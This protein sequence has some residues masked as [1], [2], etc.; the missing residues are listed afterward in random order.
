M[1]QRNKSRQGRR[2]PAYSADSMAVRLVVGL[3]LIALGLLI[4]LSIA[5]SMPGDVFAGV[6]QVS[7][8]LA[9][10]LAFLLPVFP[11]WGGGLMLFSVQRKVPLW[12]FVMACILYMLA[13]TA[14]VLVSY[15]GSPAVSLME[16]FYQLNRTRTGQPNAYDQFL[17][18]A[19]EQGANRGVSG[20]LLGMLLAWPVWRLLGAVPG[21]IVTILLAIVAAM[22]MFR[23]TP[24][25]IMAL[26]QRGSD[27]RQQ[28]DEVRRREM[29]EQEL[30][31]QQEQARMAQQQAWQYQQQPQQAL[32][33][34]QQVA[35]QNYQQPEYPPQDYQQP[36]YAYAQPVGP[37]GH[38]PSS[39]VQPYA[40]PAGWQENE[41]KPRRR[42][43]FG[44]I[45]TQNEASGQDVPKRRSIFSRP[46]PAE[47][48][49]EAETPRRQGIFERPAEPMQ[50]KQ[51]QP[52][53]QP[54]VFERPLEPEELPV[55][56]DD[57]ED[58]GYPDEYPVEEQQPVRPVRTAQP[59]AW[60]EPA[61]PAASWRNEEDEEPE[62]EPAPRRPAPKP[63]ERQQTA[64]QPVTKPAPQ[65][66]RQ[67]APVQQPAAVK[68]PQKPLDSWADTPPWEDGPVPE[69]PE[70]VVTP[71]M[72]SE[73]P[74]G[75]WEADLKLPPRRD[76]PAAQGGE[77]S[78]KPEQM[79][80]DLPVPYV[81]PSLNLLKP[82][83]PQVGVSPE[84]DAIRSQRL[85]ATLESFR[86]PAKV[87]HIT[88]GP[89]ISRF[90]L[91]LA[92]G[93]KVNKVTDLNRNIAMNMEVKSVRIE[94]P[95]PGKSLVGVEV[96][97]AKTATVTLR[98]VLESDVMRRSDK[99]L[100]VALGKDIAGVPIVCDL[101]RMPHLLIAGATG[102]GKSVCINT[103]INSLLFRRTPE[104]VRLILID[105]KV[106]E[107]QCY[108]GIPHLLIPVVS[109]PHKA[110]G[111]LAWA[112]GEMM[113]RYKKFEHKGVRAIDGY[114]AAL[115]E[116]ET[117]M[118]RIVIIIDELA[119]LMMTCKKDVEDRI[120]R[121]A[122]LARAAG[123]HLVV[124]T[125]RPSV[126]VITG[127][128]KAN[129]PSRIAFKVSSAIDS[130]TIL[131]KIGAEQLL[132][133][134]DM[135]YQP[136][137]EFTPIRVQGCFLT[138][139]EV[140]RITDFIRENC[141]ADYDPGV[142]EQLDRLEREAE[143]FTNP[144]DPEPSDMTDSDGSL[145]AQCIEMAVN[146]GQVST[147][148]IQRRLKLGYARAG[149]LV[150]EME[151]RGIISQK[152]GAKPRMC[153]ISR[154]EYEQM[155]A[156]GELDE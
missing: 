111:A 148:L 120:C 117:A 26:I 25:R 103:I 142:L 155:K 143:G 44:G 149:R 42:G 57:Q 141:P 72:Q 63:A 124:A 64:R 83:E 70:Q 67:P 56:T 105:P 19:Y 102:A 76:V 85:E 90:E 79:E 40:P 123:I 92:A 98:E 129:I 29:Y 35:Y 131:D 6:K 3:M 10:G 152:D 34:P 39:R 1:A 122:Q 84:E 54:S 58:Y 121:I 112:V 95:I 48:A 110:S 45:L 107:L 153:L 37:S 139:G 68:G 31:W 101:A 47:E 146:D 38:A 69:T 136:T 2:T 22:A 23:L 113:D 114:N 11:V 156:N 118:P 12:P 94:A 7:R 80:M 104:E 134:G 51:R 151:K 16:H 87:R 36:E 96:P 138:D 73:R 66:V 13:L 46:E 17:A 137:G 20:G 18:R 140:N 86:V 77:A 126:D 109:D 65:P 100:V 74:K 82:P 91:E 93:I 99:P 50:K 24:S 33:Q 115:E 52:A 116:G 59:A 71:V 41:Q 5:M 43:I 108:N 53:R 135:L 144:S 88:H 150:D 9:G 147:S 60:E 62:Y 130:R 127:I 49:P 32:P 61:A 21:A 154:D 132:G 125:Q 78:P 30:R 106:V 15:T 133:Y 4:F 128:I 81:Y 55:Q 28:R 8:G 75:A 14:A 89:A 119:D 27:A 145:L 97:N